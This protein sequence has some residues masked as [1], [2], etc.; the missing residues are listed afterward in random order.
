M[1]PR[2]QRKAHLH[3]FRS[4]KNRSRP[5]G[6]PRCMEQD[7]GVEPASSAWEADVLP[8]YE[9]CE[10]NYY[11]TLLLPLQGE[12]RRTAQFPRRRVT[13]CGKGVL[14]HESTVRLFCQSFFRRTILMKFR[15]RPAPASMLFRSPTAY[16]F[17]CR[18]QSFQTSSLLSISSTVSTSAPR[19]CET[20]VRQ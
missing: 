4:A 13:R 10:R 7:T 2:R 18:S 11:T 17:S 6:L 14:C 19:H 20:I 16:S 15:Y 12:N 5:H 8:M 1:R 3:A 9:S